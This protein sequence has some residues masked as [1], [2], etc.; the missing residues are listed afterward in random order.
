MVGTNTLRLN[1]ATMMQ[2]V[3]EWLERT[4]PDKPPKVTNFKYAGDVQGTYEVTVEANKEEKTSSAMS[5][6]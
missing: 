1:T 3:Q 6:K 4:M 5:V 2:I